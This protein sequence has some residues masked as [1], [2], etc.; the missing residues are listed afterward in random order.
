VVPREMFCLFGEEKGIR[1]GIAEQ[2]VLGCTALCFF[3]IRAALHLYVWYSV[4]GSYSCELLVFVRTCD[5]V[6]PF[7]LYGRHIF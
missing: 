4:T 2:K 1:V 7:S 3:K 6:I 5:I